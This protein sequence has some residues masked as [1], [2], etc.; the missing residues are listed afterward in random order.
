[1]FFLTPPVPKPPPRPDA[2]T[3]VIDLPDPFTF[4]C[5]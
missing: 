5:E 2:F 1:M 4:S 3:L